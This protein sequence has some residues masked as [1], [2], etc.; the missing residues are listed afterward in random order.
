MLKNDL[1]HKEGLLEARHRQTKASSEF[2]K[3]VGT[4]IELDRNKASA[5][6]NFDHVLG[7]LTTQ[8][9]TG[10]NELSR[11]QYDSIA[12]STKIITEVQARIK[13]ARNKDDVLAAYN[14]HLLRSSSEE[15]RKF[16]SHLGDNV[17]SGTPPPS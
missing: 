2:K 5:L 14:S 13:G 8:K 4:P 16:S 15:D 12:R 6:A 10:S 1:V 9:A 11:S 7:V 3:L 17:A